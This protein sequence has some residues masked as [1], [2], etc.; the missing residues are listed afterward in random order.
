MKYNITLWI[1]TKSTMKYE[2]IRTASKLLPNSKP[3][4]ITLPTKNLDKIKINTIIAKQQVLIIEQKFLTQCIPID[5]K[6]WV[7]HQNLLPL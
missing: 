6:R 7:Y 1:T 5:L 3:V 4:T 2:K